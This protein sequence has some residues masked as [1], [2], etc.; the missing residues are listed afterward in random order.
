MSLRSRRI[1]YLVLTLL[2]LMG[3][4]QAQADGI[5]DFVNQQ[6][7]KSGFVDSIDVTANTIVVDDRLYF[8]SA[9]TPVFDVAR[10]TNSGIRSL[11]NQMK[12][13]FKTRTLKQPTA[14]YQQQ[15]IRIWILPQ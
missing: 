10:K 1:L 5:E 7:D 8:F 3:V 13:G 12:I 14:P 15:I 2:C 11:S 4:T 9:N 6:F